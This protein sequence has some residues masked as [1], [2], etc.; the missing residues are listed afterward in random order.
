MVS[1]TNWTSMQTSL[2][3]P[4]FIEC[5]VLQP[6]PFSVF[7]PLINLSFLQS[8]PHIALPLDLSKS[9]ALFSSPELGQLSSAG[10][11]LQALVSFCSWVLWAWINLLMNIIVSLGY[12]VQTWNSKVILWRG[13]FFLNVRFLLLICYLIIFSIDLIAS[14]YP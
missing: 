6:R 8:L 9:Q 11:F 12:S 1:T 14:W 3:V 4:M 5:K 2:Y 7:E 13:Y 10:S